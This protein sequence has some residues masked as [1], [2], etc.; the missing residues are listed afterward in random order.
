MTPKPIR[1]QRASFVLGEMFAL[2][3]R[4]MGNAA[5]IKSVRIEMTR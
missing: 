5:Q 3:S 4:T 1:V 2:R